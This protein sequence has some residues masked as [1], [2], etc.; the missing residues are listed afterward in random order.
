MRAQLKRAGGPCENLQGRPSC[1]RSPGRMAVPA[2][3]AADDP[4]KE[5]LLKL[6]SAGVPAAHLARIAR[7]VGAIKPATAAELCLR[8]P[9]LL[10]VQRGHGSREAA[11]PSTQVLTA[12]AARR[13]AHKARL[14]EYMNALRPMGCFRQRPALLRRVVMF[15]AA[16]PPKTAALPD[17]SQSA[18]V[19]CLCVAHGCRARAND[20]M[21]FLRHVEE[22]HM[23]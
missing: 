15:L 9:R 19:E 14:T 4:A 16:R 6:S 20:V 13:E 18:G 7:D 10:M 21:V 22:S 5:L 1:V 2:A 8:V 12:M 11:P 3:G 17:S 23:S